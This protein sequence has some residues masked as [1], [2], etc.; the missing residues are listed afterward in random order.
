[1]KPLALEENE[2]LFGA[3][4][5]EGIVAVEP[6]GEEVMRLFI[7]QEEHLVTEDAP[8]RPF[9]LAEDGDLMEGFKK[10][11][12]VEPLSGTNDYGCLVLFQSWGDCRKAKTYL[13]KETGEPPSSLY[14]PYLFL[15]D[16]VHQFLLL[17]GKT[18]FK[19]LSVN[20]GCFFNYCITNC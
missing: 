17:S 19:G 15:S 8:F 4:P 7:R 16:P 12:Q 13:Q 2:V 1:M 6:V 14:A 10:P 9:L 18:F 20:V 5:T 3:D 11:F